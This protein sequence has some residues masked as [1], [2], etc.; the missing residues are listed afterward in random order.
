MHIKTNG[1]DVYYE[2]TGAGPW[3]TFS[4]SLA[5]DT[6]MWKPQVAEFSKRFRVL[7]YDTR[8][9]GKTSAP[10]GAY[11]LE[12]LSDDLK[13][14]LDSL[15]IRQTHYVG[16]SMGGMIGQT[17]ALKYPGV[18]SSIV[19]A[20]TTSRY[21]A[22]AEA[23]WAARIKTALEEGMEALVNPTLGRW[24]TEAFR[25]ARPELVAEVAA[26]IRSTPVPGYV[27]CCHALPKVNTTERLKEIKTPILVICGEQDMGT[28]KA[29]A[30]EIHR[31]APGSE[32]VILA[33]AAHLSN[34]EQA[35]RFNQAVAA[36]LSRHSR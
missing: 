11:T 34:L 16:L 1:I 18:F 14:L 9:H 33:N 31:N 32:L 6:S 28:P 21:G 36:F 22:E 8:G 3:L 25:A 5:T 24:F 19:L 12:I 2:V 15:A 30:E 26:M 23:L 10:Q 27:G 13:A 29:M 20:D 35:D 7:T 4:H 17:F